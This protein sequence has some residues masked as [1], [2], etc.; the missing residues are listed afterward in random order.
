MSVDEATVE[1]YLDGCRR[2]DHA[3]ILSCLTEDI[4]WT[5]FGSFH[6]Y[7]KPACVI[8]RARRRGGGP[9]AD[10]RGAVGQRVGS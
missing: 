5:V 3:R 4:E 2:N 10:G 1:T 9:R 8:H 6:L 7:G